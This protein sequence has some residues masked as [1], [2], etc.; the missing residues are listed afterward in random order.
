LTGHSTS[1]FA[2]EKRVPARIE[3]RRV[4]LTPL[5]VAHFTPA[6]QDWLCD[7]EVNR[8]SRRYGKERPSIGDLYGWLSGLA[9][10]E[11]VF[12]IET[13]AFGHIGNVKYGPISWSNLDADIAI[14]IGNRE[15]WGNGFGAEALYLVA[16]HLFW[17]RTLN[18]IHAAS[19]NPAFIRSV[20]KLGWQREGVQ[21]EEA[22]VNGKFYDSLLL[23]LLRREFSV[24]PD[25]EVNDV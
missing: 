17:E 5:T 10:D 16:K 18:R 9:K 8:Y 20:E 11:V 4:I 7:D 21:R 19:F 1:T 22:C 2:I 13:E 24:I 3:G 14:L 23:S 15:S 12:A 25:Y 6:Y